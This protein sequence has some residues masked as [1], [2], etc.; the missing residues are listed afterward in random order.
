MN[1]DARFPVRPGEHACSRF[2]L[3]SDRR[4]LTRAFVLDGLRRDNKIV[5]LGDLED[6]AVLTA[7][8]GGL[9]ADIAEALAGGRL[10][11]RPAR[12]AFLPNGRFEVE[13]AM[14][15]LRSEEALA[16]EQG[17][18]GLSITIEMSWVLSEPPGYEQL[19]EY[20]QRLTDELRESDVIA[21]R[22]Y[23][24]ARFDQAAMARI[25]TTHAV[26]MGP[27]LASIGRDGDIAAACVGPQRLL[28]LA[29][30]LDAPSAPALA[31]LVDA[32][33]HGPLVVDLADITVADARGL[34][35]LRGHLDEQLTLVAASEPVRRLASIFGWG[36]NA[37]ITIHEPG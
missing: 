27:E 14:L 12:T 36:D 29:G 3:A 32:Y 5:C 19:G 7:A 15:S 8:L 11:A 20:E 18:A 24:H 35:A 25:V 9:D 23:D 34:H 4:R 26:D 37:K 10:E 31:D 13:R 1:A 21:L 28:R 33:F 17:Y 22:Q 2:A 30:E 6:Q 16:H